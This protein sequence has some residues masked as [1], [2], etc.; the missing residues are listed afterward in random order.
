MTKF[1]FFK[2]KIKTKKMLKDFRN[3]H[4]VF[5]IDNSYDGQEKISKK[6]IN[7]FILTQVMKYNYN[8]EKESISLMG[9]GL[10]TEA[11]RDILEVGTP[12]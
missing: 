7:K 6:E 4:L 11:C 8:Q 9:E 12:S 1:K 5:E 10:T 2:N 3:K